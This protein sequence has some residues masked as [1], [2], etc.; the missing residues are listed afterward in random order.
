ML[1]G[2]SCEGARMMMGNIM[3]QL[4]QLAIPHE[5]SRVDSVLT[6]SIGICCVPVTPKVSTRDMMMRADEALRL[7]KKNGRN[8]VEV[9]N[10]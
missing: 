9:I 8:R 3:D 5:N 10:G 1:P 4:K 6:F 2:V 7:A